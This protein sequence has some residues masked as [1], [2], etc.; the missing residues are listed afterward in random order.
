MSYRQYKSVWIVENVAFAG[1]YNLYET[2]GR[3]DQ[4]SGFLG[5][6]GNLAGAREW[7]TEHPL[8]D[9]KVPRK[10]AAPS[11]NK[12]RI[13]AAPLVRKLKRGDAVSLEFRFMG[14]VSY[15]SY[16]I[17]RVR[18]NQVWIDAHDHPFDATT[19]RYSRDEGGARR[20][21]KFDGGSRAAQS[22]REHRLA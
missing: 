8:P 18:L 7:I 4:F 9:A 20:E 3:K 17:E 16:L 5:W 10:K 2:K 1:G 6:A 14:L 22:A 11:T 12:A 19:G 15:E 13:A 21:L